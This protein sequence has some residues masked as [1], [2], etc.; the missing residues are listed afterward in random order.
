MIGL[1]KKI[2]ELNKTLNTAR[3]VE[4]LRARNLPAELGDMMSTDDDNATETM[5][6]I[7][8]F[9]IEF[10]KSVNKAAGEVVSGR[11]PTGYYKSV[12]KEDFSKLGLNEMQELYN[13]DRALFEK[14]TSNEKTEEDYFNMTKNE[15]QKLGLVERQKIYDMNKTYILN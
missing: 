12:T 15:F 6:N 11:K 9:S 4:I 10:Q 2:K 7:D 1:E 8:K 14:L 3:A 5:K 13:T